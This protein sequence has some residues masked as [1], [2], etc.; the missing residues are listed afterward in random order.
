MLDGCGTLDIEPFLSNVPPHRLRRLMPG[1]V[2]ACSFASTDI[3]AQ[4]RATRS[5]RTACAGPKPSLTSSSIRLGDE[6]VAR[7]VEHLG[8]A[9]RD[10][11][12]VDVE[13]L[14]HQGGR[15]IAVELAAPGAARIRQ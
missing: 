7:T 15:Q 3:E 1:S 10:D 5:I 8:A 14:A 2:H 6:L 11:P 4:P 9:S 12:E 13:L